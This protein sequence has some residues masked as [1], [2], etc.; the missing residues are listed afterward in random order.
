MSSS[1]DTT[2][3]AQK[4]KPDKVKITIKGKWTAL[5]NRL[6][7]DSRLSRD[8]RLLGC[9]IFMHAGNS[10]K[11]FPSQEELAE[12]LSSIATVPV[13]DPQTGK[14]LKGPD[15]K[16]I[17][18]QVRR[19]ITVR[20]VQRWLAEL[21][22]AG[23]IAWRQTQLNN[24]YTLIE[25]SDS[26]STSELSGDAT[27]NEGLTGT[28]AASPR[29]TEGSH[30]NATE[31]SSR[32][33]V[34][35][36]SNVIQGSPSNT[37]EGSPPTT[38][39]SPQATAVSPSSLHRDSS[40]S[41]SSSKSASDDDD[42]Y[43][44]NKQTNSELPAHNPT[45]LFLMEHHIHAALEFADLPLGL[46]ERTYHEI[47]SRDPSATPGAVVLALR[48]ITARRK[49]AQEAGRSEDWTP[50]PA[51]REE[52]ELGAAAE[53]EEVEEPV[54]DVSLPQTTR[55]W[56]RV[57][58]MLQTQMGRDEYQR[59]LQPTSLLT[60]DDSVAT[61][62]AT[63]VMQKESIEDR[64]MS[65]IRR[66]LGDVVGAPVQLRVVIKPRSASGV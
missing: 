61:I 1:N 33:T 36:S 23:W 29:T 46:V 57:L 6:L 52:R 50:L 28:T 11:A 19:E 54:D 55:V 62:G 3:G 60:L 13:E 37:T 42:S 56:Q 22:E 9:L 48:S 59:W 4:R 65:P 15:G 51:L 21:R 34:V 41:D 35:S 31:R 25:P 8:A 12:E 2:A 10:G 58:G 38:G 45:S 5:P 18:E 24:E 44:K 63:T 49:A 27:L 39:G 20:S 64:Y 16:A 66:I 26:R 14:P 53:V 30:S 32:A 43:S 40:D 47:T 7:T 17:T